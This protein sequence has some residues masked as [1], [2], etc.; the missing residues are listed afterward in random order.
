MRGGKVICR[1]ESNSFLQFL[2]THKRKPSAPMPTQTLP[3][4]PAVGRR[5]T[6]RSE[7]SSRRCQSAKTSISLKV[8]GERRLQLTRCNPCNP[9]GSALR[10]REYVGFRARYFFCGSGKGVSRTFSSKPKIC[11]C[12]SVPSFFVF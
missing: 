2:N 4:L 12:R 1:A 9:A 8:E 5:G 3:R 6:A 10:E 11:G 7:P